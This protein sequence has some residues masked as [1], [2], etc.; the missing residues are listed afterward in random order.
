MKQLSILLVALILAAAPV[1]VAQANDESE[2]EY[3]ARY[4]GYE[5]DVALEG[6]VSMTWLLMAALSAAGV[7]V[8]FIHPRR[9]HL[10]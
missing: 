3:D 6:G 8:L 4:Y 10:D 7:G 2:I 5:P 9:S 1:S